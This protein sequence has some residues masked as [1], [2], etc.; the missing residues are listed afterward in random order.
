MLPGNPKDPQQFE[1][2]CSRAKIPQE[3]LLYLNCSTQISKGNNIK[4]I[5][6]YFVCWL[7]IIWNN[8]EKAYSQITV[9]YTILR[10]VKNKVS[11]SVLGQSHRIHGF[12]CHCV[13]FFF[14]CAHTQIW[15]RTD[16]RLVMFKWPHL[17]WVCKLSIIPESTWS[18]VLLKFWVQKTCL[19]GRTTTW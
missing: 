6:S 14:N 1:N 18:H 2:H 17:F 4:Q 13:R 3:N 5:P 11:F 10:A 9:V 19:P 12:Y 7:T 15:T 16:H 8:M